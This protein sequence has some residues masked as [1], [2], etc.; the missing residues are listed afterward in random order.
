MRPAMYGAEAHD[1]HGSVVVFFDH[2]SWR[3][4]ARERPQYV[5]KALGRYRRAYAAIGRDGRV[6]T[7]GR[8]YRRIWR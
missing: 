2:A 7:V 6:A 5:L 1:H 4:L 8:R 3:Q